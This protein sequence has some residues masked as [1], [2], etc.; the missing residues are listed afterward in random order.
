M[1]WGVGGTAG[2]WL[3]E[4]KRK[5]K[6]GVSKL[7]PEIVEHQFPEYLLFAGLQNPTLYA[8]SDLTMNPWGLSMIIPT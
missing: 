1:P 3:K 4:N 2:H 6:A 8:F 5:G 7:G